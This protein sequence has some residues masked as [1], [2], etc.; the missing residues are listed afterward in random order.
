MAREIRIRGLVDRQWMG[1]TDDSGIFVQTV[2]WDRLTSMQ[3][4]AGDLGLAAG[5][6][7]STAGS[8]GYMAAIMGNVIVGSP[9]SAV[10]LTATHNIVA[11]VIGKYD[12]VGTNASGYFGAAMLA[13][14]GDGATAARA[15][16][17]AVMGGD[18]TASSAFAAFGVDWNASTV[19]SRF[20]TGLDLEGPAAHNDYL[21][22]RYNQSFIRMGGRIQNAVG[23]PVTVND[24]CVLAGTAAPTN[25]TSGTGAGVAAAGSLYIRQSGSDSVLSINTNTLASPTWTVVGSQS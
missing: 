4:V 3:C 14:I 22:P 5:A 23:D 17:L 1:S 15:A 10:N 8:P 16:V 9:G 20:N 21:I 13:E 25:G 6:G 11:G 12:H 2:E 18:S 19:A 24:I 7:S